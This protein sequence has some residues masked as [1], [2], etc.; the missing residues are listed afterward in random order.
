MYIE[1]TCGACQEMIAGEL[2]RPAVA[3]RWDRLSAFWLQMLKNHLA[4]C[5][6]RR[7]RVA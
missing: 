6:S 2:Y 4:T 7:K 3:E 1:I 5:P